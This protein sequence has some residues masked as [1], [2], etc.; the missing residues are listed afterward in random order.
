MTNR[1]LLE[2]LSWIAGIISALLAIFLWVTSHPELPHPPVAAAQPQ[3]ATPSAPS[4][5]S[6]KGA[7]TSTLRTEVLPRLLWKEKIGVASW[8]NN[9]LFVGQFLYV[10]SSGTSWNSPDQLDGIYAFDVRTGK[11]LWFV[12]SKI[13]VN[14]IAY[15]EGMI[16]GGNDLGEVFA[17]SA[18]S[19]EIVWKAHVDG[20]VYAKPTYSD[21]GIVV[22]TGAG[23]LYL[24][25]LQTGAILDKTKVDGGIRAGLIAHETDVYVATE[26]GWLYQFTTFGHFNLW[27]KISLIYPDEY[28]SESGSLPQSISRFSSLGNNKYSKPAIY[29][30]PLLTKDK[31]IV[32][33]VRETYYSYPAVVAIR[34]KGK[35]GLEE[36]L[37]FGTDPLKKVSD[38]FGN[39]RFTPG[40]FKNLLIFG[41][42]YSNS[43]YAIDEED[44]KVVWS[45]S[46]GQSMFQHWSSPLVADGSVYIARHDGLVHKINP[47]NGDRIWSVFLGS[48]KSAGLTFSR[49]SQLPG[50]NHRTQWNPLAS[51]SIFS[52]PA[53]SD[54]LLAVTTEEGYLYVM[55]TLQR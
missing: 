7:S 23:N 41:N 54:G 18:I 39:I 10:G 16:V 20:A 22:G 37:W 24:L 1:P 29:A 27:K 35:G 46:L 3:P 14:D 5:P 50:E 34:L 47:A 15:I 48:N 11:K 53:Y 2:I 33:F 55:D 9:P 13:D 51:K 44:G 8:R 30:A 45:T 28:G 12:P 21:T 40:Q 38:D 4:N 49:N 26:S 31:I 25:N 17:I 52:T 43:V 42:P 6:L 36:Y 19:G 32:G